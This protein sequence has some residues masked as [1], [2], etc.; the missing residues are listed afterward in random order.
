ML[1]KIL[2]ASVVLGLSCPAP[3]SAEGVCRAACSWSDWGQRTE[4]CASPSEGLLTAALKCWRQVEPDGCGK[5]CS[6]WLAAYDACQASGVP[7]C[8]MGA[9]SPECNACIYGACGSATAACSFDETECVPCA[10]WIGGG[11]DPSY[12]CWYSIGPADDTSS[13]A[14][15]T[16]SAKCGS[17]CGGGYLDPD[18][19][20]FQC[21]TCIASKCSAKFDACSAN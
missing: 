14:C 15:L 19:A 9:A 18:A 16:C 3:A 7:S 12:L 11:W 6:S 10:D 13:C 20:S 21:G 2:I 1:K 5:A 8:T 4:V 17:A